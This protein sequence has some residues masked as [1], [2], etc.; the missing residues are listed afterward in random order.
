M[1]TASV[2]ALHHGWLRNRVDRCQPSATKWAVQSE[3]AAAHYSPP[4]Q[5]RGGLFR[6]ERTSAFCILI[7]L[8]NWAS[9]T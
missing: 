3:T 2:S 1:Q 9:V 6:M 5:G 8:D 7:E 4:L